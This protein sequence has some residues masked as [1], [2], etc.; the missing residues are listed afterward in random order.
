MNQSQNQ[1]NGTL[2]QSSE[3]PLCKSLAEDD[4]AKLREEY[5]SIDKDGN[6][7]ISKI[8]LALLCGQLKKYKGDEILEFNED[9]VNTLFDMIDTDGNGKIDF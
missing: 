3:S 1:Q 8:E 5:N 4:I 9:D 7:F 2:A 6:G